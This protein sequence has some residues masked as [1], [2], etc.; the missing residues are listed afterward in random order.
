ME[1]KPDFGALLLWQEDAPKGSFGP[2]IS[3]AREGERTKQFTL[4]VRQGV[5]QPMKVTL[6]AANKK[7]AVKFARNRWPGATVE[8]A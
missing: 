1:K 6:H 5:A 4:R 7:D 2:G 3:R 8:A